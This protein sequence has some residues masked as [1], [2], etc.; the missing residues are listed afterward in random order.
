MFTSSRHLLFHS[1]AFLLGMCQSGTEGALFCSL[2]SVSAYYTKI[3]KK[4]WKKTDTVG[5]W[6]HYKIVYDAFKFKILWTAWKLHKVTIIIINKFLKD[7]VMSVC[8]STKEIHSLFLPKRQFRNQG[9]IPQ[10]FSCV[11][12]R[13]SSFHDSSQY[14]I[15]SNKVSHTYKQYIHSTRSNTRLFVP[16]MDQMSVK[17]D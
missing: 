9:F 1:P 5:H 15:A 4:Q 8:V 10:H 12:P 2:N 17:L 13:L 3:S 11:C 7:L 16:L 14:F 6:L